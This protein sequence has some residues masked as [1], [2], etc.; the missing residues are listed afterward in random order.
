M[1]GI[2]KWGDL[3]IDSHPHNDIAMSPLDINDGTVSLSVDGWGE[4]NHSS[5]NQDDARQIIDFLK[6]QFKLK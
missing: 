6:E 1:S 2:D 3:V 4:R 5:I